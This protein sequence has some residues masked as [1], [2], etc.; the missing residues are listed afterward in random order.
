MAATPRTSVHSVGGCGIQ[1]QASR[2]GGRLLGIQEGVR[3]LVGSAPASSEEREREQRP[4]RTVKSAESFLADVMIENLKMVLSSD[5][6]F[7]PNLGL[8]VLITARVSGLSL[9]LC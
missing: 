5:S 9:Q 3:S 1:G 2:S 4:L 7:S 8:I 6:S